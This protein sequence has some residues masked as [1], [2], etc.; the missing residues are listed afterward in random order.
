MPS[1]A[2]CA[3]LLAAILAEVIA[4]TALARSESITRLFP[5]LIAISGDALV[6]WPLSVPI[7]VQPSGVVHAIWS[8]LGIVFIAHVAWIGY[9]QRLDLPAVIG[10]ALIL[11][12][13]SVA[14]VFFRSILQ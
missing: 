7:R 13:V 6:F 12:G 9:G 10:L 2:A 14:N 11:S 8:G 1:P 5:R 3:V 4:A